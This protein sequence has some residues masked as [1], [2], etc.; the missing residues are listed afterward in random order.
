MSLLP[1]LRHDVMGPIV[2]CAWML[3]STIGVG[4]SVALEG[5]RLFSCRSPRDAATVGVWSEVALFGM[6]ATLTLP[7]L[8]VLAHHP[9]LYTA[10]PQIRETSYGILLFE[11]L[12][13]GLLGLALAALLDGVLSNVARHLSHGTQAL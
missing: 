3:V 11:Y 12:P 9:H 2:V 8:G 10:D 7:M 13:P 4:G 5:Q 6:L 1:M